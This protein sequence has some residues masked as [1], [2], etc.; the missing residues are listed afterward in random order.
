MC[1]SGRWC[2]ALRGDVELGAYVRLWLVVS[3]G[4]V[5]DD[6]WSGTV[7]FLRLCFLV[8]GPGSLWK[9][10]RE[11]VVCWLAMFVIM[12]MS[13]GAWEMFSAVSDSRI[14][15]RDSRLPLSLAS[16]SIQS[17]VRVR[18]VMVSR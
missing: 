11:Y 14:L 9:E 4:G 7:S 6:H 2:V 16:R 18:V 10:W 17:T 5:R 13:G 8:D 15:R 3:R 1:V 12:T